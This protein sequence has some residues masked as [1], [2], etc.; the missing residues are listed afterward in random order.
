MENEL[1]HHG[2]KGQ[3]WGIRRFQNKDGSLTN[4][5][6][7]RRRKDG[8]DD[9]EEPK[10]SSSKSTK[11]SSD[12]SKKTTSKSTKGKSET[13]EKK[14]EEK[15]EEVVDPAVK[16]KEVLE[17]RSAKA[18]Y[19]NAALFD[20]NELRAAYNRLQLEKNIKELAP[21]E[22]SKGE[23]YV[24]DFIHYGTKASKAMGTGIDI[25][26]N[27]AKIYN[28]FSDEG[29]L[30]II[31]TGGKSK[32]KKKSNNDDD[33]DDDNNDN[34]SKSN[35]NSKKDSK[36][37]KDSKETERSNESN[38]SKGS[39]KEKPFSRSKDSKS[40]KKTDK[41][42]EPEVTVENPRSSR[43]KEKKYRGENQARYKKEDPDIIDME[44]DKDSG[45]Y[46]QGRQAVDDRWAN[47]PTSKIVDPQYR[48]SGQNYVA[49]LLDEPKK[50]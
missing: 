30:P 16:K 7:K 36:G 25:Y 6:R 28:A 17:S 49:G 13:P 48:L 42:D 19:E 32:D 18:L 50:K 14:P 24:N 45:T 21:K 33:N 11:G 26:N 31:N 43:K 4:A 2:V 5:G 37:S 35:R 41:N 44:Y 8:G 20:D 29:N 46:K 1:Q 34:N 10:K 22:V 38:E 47:T 9:A 15:S 39:K 3:K 40:D 27:V 23:Q 12:D